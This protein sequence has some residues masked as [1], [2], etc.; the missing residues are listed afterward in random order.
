MVGLDSRSEYHLVGERR[1]GFVQE[2]FVGEWAGYIDFQGVFS[3][4][5]F[6]RKVFDHRYPGKTVWATCIELTA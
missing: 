5:R 3:L 6:S 4:A 2:F 1:N